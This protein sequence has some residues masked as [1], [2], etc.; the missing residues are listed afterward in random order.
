MLIN[1]QLDKEIIIFFTVSFTTKHALFIKLDCCIL[2]KKMIIYSIL[3]LRI[4][5]YSAWLTISNS[6]IHLLYLI[7]FI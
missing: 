3:K 5:F 2:Y 6:K 4:L 7:N 1:Y